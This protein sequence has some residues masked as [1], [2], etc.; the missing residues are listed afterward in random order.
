M[1]HVSLRRNIFRQQKERTSAQ[2][3]DQPVEPHPRYDFRTVG[4]RGAALPPV[5]FF[6]PAPYPPDQTD[7]RILA[8]PKNDRLCIREEWTID[9]KRHG[10]ARQALVRNTSHAA[11]RSCQ[12][13]E[14]I[15]V[16][17]TKRKQL[18]K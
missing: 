3:A 6:L 10:R 17:A 8:K 13:P 15:D 1:V 2:D 9:S 18:H 12:W 5:V 11:V 16:D 7:A 4:L 14:S